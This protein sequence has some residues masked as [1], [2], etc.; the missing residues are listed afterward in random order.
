MQNREKIGL[1]I[2]SIFS[3]VKNFEGGLEFEEKSFYV[4]ETSLRLDRGDQGPISLKEGVSEKN[5]IRN[6]MLK[7]GKAYDFI[8]NI[9]RSGEGPNYY[10]THGESLTYYNSSYLSFTRE[11]RNT[12]KILYS[13]FADKNVFFLVTHAERTRKITISSYYLYKHSKNLTFRGNL[14]V[15]VSSNSV[16][17][18][19]NITRFGDTKIF[20]IFARET[21]EDLKTDNWVYF[22]YHGYSNKILNTYR[23]P[24][25]ANEP[26]YNTVEAMPSNNYDNYT[27]SYLVQGLQ[28]PYFKKNITSIE[29][30]VTV[31][32]RSSPAKYFKSE[33]FDLKFRERIDQKEWNL[34][35][36]G[37]FFPN[38][39]KNNSNGFKYRKQY[40]ALVGNYSQKLSIPILINNIKIEYNTAQDML[41]VGFE[42]N[43]PMGMFYASTP[44]Q[45][46]SQVGRSQIINLSTDWI[47][48]TVIDSNDYLGV[49]MNN[50]TTE[51]IPSPTFNLPD[52]VYIEKFGFVTI[53]RAIPRAK[54]ALWPIMMLKYSSVKKKIT[55]VMMTTFNSG[56]ASNFI[57]TMEFKGY[58]DFLMNY[59]SHDF[60]VIKEEK[61]RRFLSLG[62]LA[63]TTL[64]V[65]L[66]KYKGGEYL[67]FF[68]VFGYPPQKSKIRI[69]INL[70]EDLEKVW[71][72]AQFGNKHPP[73]THIT[74]PDPSIFKID[75]QNVQNVSKNHYFLITGNL[76]A[77]QKVLPSNSSNRLDIDF[78]TQST[79]KN[80]SV[81]AAIKK[82]HYIDSIL[83][84]RQGFLRL[85]NASTR[86]SRRKTVEVLSN[87]SLTLESEFE[88][89]TCDK[90]YFQ[91]IP[92]T[93]NPQDAYLAWEQ[94]ATR[95]R[96][97]LRIVVR[98][99]SWWVIELSTSWL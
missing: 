61:G 5:K 29:L 93:K 2:F 62:Q 89:I 10:V 96:I 53:G 9:D 55:R 85:R 30:R 15:P 12:E 98:S 66:E 63:N 71:N 75:D 32:K 44:N 6:L 23:V 11:V 46:T 77:P 74:S 13:A 64:Q 88:S 90:H 19:I 47:D 42:P 81:G 49:T 24:K 21:S 83:T 14:T 41:E 70:T 4:P 28:D 7:K 94:L 95:S 36:Q 99:L 54:S 68:D 65:D 69:Q 3:L 35:S 58:T 48:G 8:G 73:T 60:L 78:L 31:I 25:E 26:E 27:Y 97:S 38:V 67:E 20:Y 91:T 82:V 72:S 18:G 37:Y 57:Q 34:V 50:Y 84:L 79:V 1:I 22:E 40:A 59:D 43:Q 51:F 16:L 45:F 80:I 52:D 87:C 76:R 17:K 56:Q 33:V 92:W 86:P 39:K